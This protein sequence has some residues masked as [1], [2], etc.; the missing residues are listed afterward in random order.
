MAVV[1]KDEFVRLEKS[2]EFYK[3]ALLNLVEFSKTDRRTKAQ[4]L[5]RLAAL[6]VEASEAKPP[7]PPPRLTRKH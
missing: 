4:L 1:T 3:N 7:S 5:K 2:I 6:E